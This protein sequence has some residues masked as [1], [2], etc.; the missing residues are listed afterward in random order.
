MD[1]RKSFVYNL[2]GDCMEIVSEVIKKTVSE[3]DDGIKRQIDCRLIVLNWRKIVG[4]DADKIFPA[5]IQ[6]TTLILYSDSPALKDSFKF[7][8]PKIIQQI[9]SYFDAEVITKITFQFTPT[10]NFVQPA[11]IVPSE[12]PPKVEVTLTDEEIEECKKKSAVIVN[13]TTRRM[14]FDCLV[15]KMRADKRLKLSGWKK[16]LLC[17]NL[18]PPNENL[19]D[20]CKVNERNRM[21]KRIRKIFH[22]APE[23]KFRDV[24]KII[25]EEFPYLRGECTLQF[26]ESARMAL[27]QQTANLLSFNDSESPLAKFFVR[28]VRQ[29]P[30][31]LLTEKII[32]RTLHEFRFDLADRPPFQPQ[33][34]KKINSKARRTHEKISVQD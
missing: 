1:T 11:Q 33:T 21:T 16:C 9:N 6:G 23:T 7:R 32:S 20:V 19:C 31:E 4:D 27:I 25:A 30:E 12:E 15:T 17:E 14:L 5:D 34:F 8:A 22:D 18:C 13:E 29:L 10:K 28:L 26:I 24:Q 3:M 2:I